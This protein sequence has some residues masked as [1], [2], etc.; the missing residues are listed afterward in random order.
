MAGT[1]AAAAPKRPQ[2]TG[3]GG[4]RRQSPAEEEARVT[5]RA[6]RDRR[7]ADARIAEAKEIL[8]Q[9]KEAGE[10]V[11]RSQ[12]ERPTKPIGDGRAVVIDAAALRTAEASQNRRLGR[13]IGTNKTVPGGAFLVNGK[14]VDA[15]GREVDDDLIPDRKE[16]EE[17]A[18]EDAPSGSPTAE[19]MTGGVTAP[20]DQVPPAP[21]SVQG[22]GSADDDNTGV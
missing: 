15:N 9:K 2:V 22:G 21:A 11:E 12:A 19:V 7:E 17:A 5:S 20:N 4:G 3:G 6:A 14:W 10:L 1:N 16:T 18:A 13:M 8:R